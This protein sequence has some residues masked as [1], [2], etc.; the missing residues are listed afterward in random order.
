MYTL[1]QII[2]RD[3]G[4]YLL[5]DNKERSGVHPVLDNKERSGCT[6]SVR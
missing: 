3:Q 1:Y 2:R 5:L 4:L 6:P